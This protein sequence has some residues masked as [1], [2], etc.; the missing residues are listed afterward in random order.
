MKVDVSILDALAD[1]NFFKLHFKGG[2][3]GAWRV[4][5]GALFGLPHDENSTIVLAIA[6]ALDES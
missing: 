2:A 4:F 5:L 1:V 6:L 3:W